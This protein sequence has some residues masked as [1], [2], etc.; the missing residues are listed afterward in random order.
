MIFSSV[1][2]L[3]LFLPSVLA[4]SL[5]VGTKGYGQLSIDGGT[6]RADRLYLTNGIESVLALN[7]GMLSVNTSV[8]SNGVPLMVGD[9]TN[10]ATF[11]QW[12][13]GATSVHNDMAFA[14]NSTWSIDADAITTPV[15]DVS[16]TLS[17]APGVMLSLSTTNST[18][19]FLDGQI[20]GYADSVTTTPQVLEDSELQVKLESVNTRKAMVLRYQSGSLFIIR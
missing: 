13:G 9:G 4:A 2:F 17:F 16:G 15:L 6:C 1:T 12:G 5:V 19:R 8:I 20:I 10:P 7:S 18:Y 11:D 3:F 14:A